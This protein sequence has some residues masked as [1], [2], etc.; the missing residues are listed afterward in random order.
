M[1]QDIFTKQLLRYVCNMKVNYVIYVRKR[2]CALS[3]C[4]ML[5]YDL[6]MLASV[7]VGCYTSMQPYIMLV[8][9]SLVTYIKETT[10]MELTNSALSYIAYYLGPIIKER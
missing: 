7:D 1:V 2:M 10:D 8:I 3:S 4:V 5:M 9:T 6:C